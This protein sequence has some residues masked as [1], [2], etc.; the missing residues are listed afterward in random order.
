MW[1]YVYL[2]LSLSLFLP[3][4]PLSFLPSFTFFLLALCW[5]FL[6]LTLETFALCRK[7]AEQFDLVYFAQWGKWW[8]LLVNSLRWIMRSLMRTLHA[9]DGIVCIY[10][11][12]SLHSSRISRCLDCAG[13]STPL[14]Y[15]YSTHYALHSKISELYNILTLLLK[16]FDFA[17]KNY[18]V[19]LTTLHFRALYLKSLHLIT[20]H[21]FYTCV[22]LH[23]TTLN[24]TNLRFTT[25]Q[26][27]VSNTTLWNSTP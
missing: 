24:I 19:Y 2:S 20:L 8:W 9:L 13:N 6:N 1:A 27:A 3:H 18:M 26:S 25:L 5:H 17:L 11:A 12:L 15:L 16:T 10:L 21:F 23:F 4:L 14:V 22:D 7:S